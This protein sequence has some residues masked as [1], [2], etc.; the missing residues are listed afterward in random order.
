M[1]HNNDLAEDRTNWA[2]D[3][4]ILANER[5]F[6]GWMRTGMASLAVAIGLKAVFGEF[7]PTWAAKSVAT[8]FVIAAIYIFWA[9]HD[10]ATKTLERLEDHHANAQSNAR[11]KVL[12]LVFSGASFAV[13]VILWML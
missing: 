5:T 3:R 2:E 11:M 13:G 10:T 8:I 6:A 7:D 12:A 9:A 4:T 1:S